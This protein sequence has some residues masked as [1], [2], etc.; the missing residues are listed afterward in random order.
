MYTLYNFI[1]LIDCVVR[2]KRLQA[3]LAR[4]LWGPLSV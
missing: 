2:V 3:D 4:G 1:M